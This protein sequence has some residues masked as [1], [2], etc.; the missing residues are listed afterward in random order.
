MIKNRVA[1]TMGWRKDC[2][3]RDSTA[4]SV[5]AP[6][7]RNRESENAGCELRAVGRAGVLGAGSPRREARCKIDHR[8]CPHTD[9]RPA[10]GRNPLAPGEHR[11]CESGA[12]IE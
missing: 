7:L 2:I 5:S 3:L 10:K 8:F 1:P 11:M 6:G 9:V 4:P 12:H